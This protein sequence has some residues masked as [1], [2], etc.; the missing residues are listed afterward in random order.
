M[1]TI[2]M[3]SVIQLA[4]ALHVRN[5]LIDA[6][7]EG[8]RFAALADTELSQGEERTRELITVAVGGQY[9]EGVHASLADRSGVEIV[10]VEVRAPLPIIG[11][12]GAPGLLEV[13][14]HAVLETL[15]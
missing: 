12:V 1:L 2:L 5:T 15:S 10:T 11:L 13:Q 3:V 4:L 14:G 7:S 9:A 8:A 6:A